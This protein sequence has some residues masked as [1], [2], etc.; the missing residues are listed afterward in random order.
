MDQ[1]DCHEVLR[2]LSPGTL[3][4][5]MRYLVT[6]M[7]VIPQLQLW[8]PRVRFFLSYPDAVPSNETHEA[9]TGLNGHLR[10]FRNRLRV[11]LVGLH[12]FTSTFDTSQFDK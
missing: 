11:I 9:G 7:D 4:I 5:L 1:S 6:Y 12:D 2:G 3:Q 8:L 10:G